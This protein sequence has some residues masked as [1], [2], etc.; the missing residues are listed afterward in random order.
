MLTCT[1]GWIINWF[2]GETAVKN[3]CKR[4]M[5]LFGLGLIKAKSSRGCGNGQESGKTGDM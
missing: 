1:A 4:L 3:T 2:E 5:K